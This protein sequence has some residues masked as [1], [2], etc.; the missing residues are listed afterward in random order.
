MESPRNA[1]WDGISLQFV[2]HD[3]SSAASSATAGLPW[4]SPS[5]TSSSSSAWP[6]A[7]PQVSARASPAYGF[8]FGAGDALAGD[9]VYG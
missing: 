4:S 6:Q 3:V 5:P 9:L 7:T 1:D 8:S 2:C